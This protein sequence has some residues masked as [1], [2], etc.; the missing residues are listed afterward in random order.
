MGFDRITTV[1][2][3]PEKIL[4]FQECIAALADAS[5]E[6]DEPWSWTAHQVVFGEGPTIHFASRAESFAEIERQGQVEG[7]WT[8]VFGE[9]RGLESMSRANECITGMQQT[10]SVDRPDLSYASDVGDPSEYPY[11]AVTLARAKPGGFE[12]CEELIRKIAEAIPKVGDTSRL[13]TYQVMFGQMGSY[14]TIRPLRSLADLDAQLP[15]VELLN[16]A[17]GHAEGGLLW[18]TGSESIEEARREVVLYHP[19]LSNPPQA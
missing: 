17:F 12:A 16:Q 15:A 13:L 4:A 11:A 5:A 8:R 18:R 1:T 6:K 10:L 9:S 2:L 3:R 14:F 19:E 7:L